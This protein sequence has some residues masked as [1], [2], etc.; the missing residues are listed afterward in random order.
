MPTA[1]SSRNSSEA[2][3]AL[4]LTMILTVVALATLAGALAWAATSTRLTYR[5]NQYSR[6]VA[7]AEAAT[8]KSVSAIS[9]DFLSGGERLVTDNL[10]LYRQAP[11]AAPDTTYWQRWA[12]DDAS[13]NAGRTY[14]AAGPDP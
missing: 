13:G 9:R 1:F 6:S 5:S 4:L 8:E 12:F 3:S 14:G 11:L 2:A 10:N 7:A